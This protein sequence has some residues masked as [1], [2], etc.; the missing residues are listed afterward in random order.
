M[1]QARQEDQ[2][3]PPSRIQGG[4]LEITNPLRWQLVRFSHQVHDLIPKSCGI[5][6][7]N[8]ALKIPSLGSICWLEIPVSDLTRAAAFYSAVFNWSTKEPIPA[9]QV[10]GTSSMLLF[11]HPQIYGA[12]MQMDSSVSIPQWRDEASSSSELG[13]MKYRGVLTSF[14][15]ESI[16]DVL[17]AVVKN[18]GKV[19]VLW[20]TARNGSGAKA[21]VCIPSR[22][23]PETLRKAKTANRF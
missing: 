13:A 22:S 21:I 15:V 6:C 19:D 9:S 7:N 5:T 16:A 4:L 18:G 3:K 8:G 2:N 14:S 12:F 17:E 11:S 23:A 1:A 10:P 20:D